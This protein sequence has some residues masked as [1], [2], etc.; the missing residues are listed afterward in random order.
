MKTATHKA[1]VLIAR[2]ARL[3]LFPALVAG[4]LTPPSLAG[5]SITSGLSAPA[6][7]GFVDDLAMRGFNPQPE[8]PLDIA[9]DAIELTPQSLRSI[10]SNSDVMFNP[11]PEPPRPLLYML[12]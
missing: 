11:Q 6:A 5:P 3:V 4:A 8:P 12:K 1:R 2:I 7:S 10:F 9:R